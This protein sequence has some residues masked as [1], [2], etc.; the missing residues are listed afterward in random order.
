MGTA[1]STAELT[2][3]D[4]EN[5]LSDEERCKVCQG[6]LAPRFSRA[7]SPET[8]VGIGDRHRFTVEV[9]SYPEAEVAWYREQEKEPVQTSDAVS[10][11]REAPGRHHLQLEGVQLQHQVSQCTRTR[12]VKL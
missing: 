9:T 7:L 2:L 10:T 3:A 11:G 6:Q 1:E 8:V 4:I 5:Q 12:S